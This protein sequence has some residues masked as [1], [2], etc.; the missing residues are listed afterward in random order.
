MK[1]QVRRLI[2]QTAVRARVSDLRQLSTRHLALG[3]AA[4]L[5][6]VICELPLIYMLVLSL[7]PGGGFTFESYRSLLLDSRQRELLLNSVV[8]GAT[9]ALVATVLGAPLGFLLGR[10]ELPARHILR[11]ALVVP[12]TLPPYVLGL[13]WIYLTG[14]TGI[15]STLSGT[16]LIASWTYTL[17]GCVVV[18]SVN[19]YPLAM[20]ATEAATRLI[21]GRLEE[22]GLLVASPRRVLAL[23]TLPLIA[24]M[25][26]AT[27]LLIFIL[28]FSEFGVPGLLRVRVFTTEVFTSFAAFYDFSRATAFSFPLLLAALIATLSLNQLVGERFLTTR[29]SMLPARRFRLGRL[30]V[31]VMAWVGLVFVA[32]VAVPLLVL[33]AETRGVRAVMDELSSSRSAITNSIALSM[34]SAL[35]AVVIG[36]F[37]GY[38]RARTRG[39]FGRLAD[40]LFV[41]GFAAPST[42]IGVGL[43]E[44]WNRPGFGG[45]I[46][47]SPL[48]IVLAHLARFLPVAVLILAAAVRQ[49]SP[50]LE[51]AAEVA[52]AS[53][54]RM[55]SRI[56]LPQIMTP[57]AAAFVVTFILTFGELGATVLVSPPGESTLPVRVYTLIANA[58]SSR[59]ASL[60]L[61]Q[62]TIVLLPLVVFSSLVCN[63]I[64]QR[65]PERADQIA[66]LGRDEQ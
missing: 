7:R 58:P 23:I 42:V 44:F 8:L 2:S 18:L 19:L 17:V 15:A 11:I 10:T 20:L 1:S 65:N 60:A 36:L 52:G 28:A 24:P 46:Y 41:V 35:L 22:A 54:N 47:R 6:I 39:W 63:F 3:S 62:T 4:F 45:E 56:V 16:N 30:R 27:S 31:S 14:P 5:F 37:L 57:G 21:D 50:S 34:I 12:L 25:V 40:I 43:I 29:R 38:W 55:F 48:I 9:S 64:R 33:A 32:T 51:E 49:V 66:W 13:A 53:W 59:V 26:A 61:I